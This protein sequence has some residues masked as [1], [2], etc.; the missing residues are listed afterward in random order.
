M[1][2]PRRNQVDLHC[3]TACSDGVLEPLELYAQLAAAGTTL[4]AITDHDTLAGVRAIRREGLGRAGSTDGPRIIAGVEINTTAGEDLPGAEGLARADRE[5]HIIGLG[6]D[7]EDTDLNAALA[8]Q[9]GKRGERI[10]RIL[11]LLASMDLDVRDHM[12]VADDGK[13]AGRPHVARALV[14][15]GHVG[16]VDEA[17]ARFLGIDGPAYAA[18]EGIGPREAIAAIAAAGGIAVLAHRRDAPEHPVLIEGLK[19]AGLEG[20]EV[21]HRGFDEADFERMGRFADA[22]ELI[23][24]GGT[25][26][27]GNDGKTYAT[28]QA[29]THVP[30]E[31]GER[32]L[33]R[34]AR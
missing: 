15:A 21:Y 11:E 17:F 28:E 3:H 9:R 16:S 25:D 19:R 24:S 18:R 29:Q 6:V 20:I 4:V 14:A 7:T 22:T 23:A 13:A 31:V 12:P 33:A 30:D 5:L 26:F 2:T 8:A 10:E 27:H 32:V 34:L 1:T